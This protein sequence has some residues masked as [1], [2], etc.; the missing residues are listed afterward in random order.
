[1]D[2]LEILEDGG[3]PVGWKAVKMPVG[4]QLGETSVERKD[5]EIVGH[6]LCPF[7]GTM[8]LDVMIWGLLCWNCGWNGF[9]CKDVW[10]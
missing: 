8:G 7:C 3:L 10:R 9:G 6:G 5:I 2:I 4:R 1:M